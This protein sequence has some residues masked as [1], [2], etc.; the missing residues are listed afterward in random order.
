MHTLSVSTSGT[1]TGTVTSSPPGINCGSDCS[2]SYSEGTVVALSA[3]PG[4]SSTFAGW[5]GACSGTGACQVTMNGATAVGAAFNSTGGGTDVFP[6]S[7]TV[8]VGALAGGTVANLGSDDNA[9][10][11]VHSN[12]TTPKTATW[13]GAFTGVDNATTTLEATYIGKS[14]ITCT[15]VISIWRWTDSTWVDLDTRQVGTTEV[16]VSG[17]GPSGSLD[18]FVSGAS[19][20]GDVRVR[21]SCSNTGASVFSLSGD[22]L[23]ITV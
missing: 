7:F 9:Y 16:E 1:G 2:E 20:V 14:S 15:Q 19:G 8:L 6:S 10:L 21:V 3:S 22:L 17:I 4:P 18:P 5:S 12:K 23:K 13:F 11:V